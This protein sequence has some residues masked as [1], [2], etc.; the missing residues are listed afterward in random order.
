MA[1]SVHSA[2][3]ELARTK[4][5]LASHARVHELIARAAPLEQVLTELVAGIE[6]YDGSVIPCAV[7]LDPESNTLHPG[8]GPALPPEYLAAIDGVV[9][10][11]EVGSC[12]AAAWSGR[13]MI[14]EDMEQDPKW[15]PILPLTRAANLRHC[16]SNPIKA[17][18][19]EV[20]GTLALY[21]P[22]ARAPQP[23]HLVLLQDG[24]R[25]AGIA[26]E[27][28]R[29]MERLVH[30]ATHDALTRPRHPRAI[31]QLV[32]AAPRER[33]RRHRPRRAL[34]RPRRPQAAERQPRARPHGRV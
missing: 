15:A 3:R 6:R 1:H 31:F 26:I 27:R 22:N 20:L 16:W 18:D 19:G 25:V 7:L 33:A 14:T 30:D 13:M 24:A 5:L 23:E 17:P 9:I 8:A 12:G 34:R 10:G 21:G 28:H 2:E 4:D 11:P 32:G 29:A